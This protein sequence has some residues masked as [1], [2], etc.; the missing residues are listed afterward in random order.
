M[1]PEIV[2][3]QLDES[4]ELLSLECVKLLQYAQAKRQFEGAKDKSQVDHS[5]PFI[6]EVI[7]NDMELAAEELDIEV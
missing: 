2:A 6:A 4:P 7:E 3:K 5:A 1:L